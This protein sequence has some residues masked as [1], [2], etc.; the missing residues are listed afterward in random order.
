MLN[1]CS[2][3]TDSPSTSPSFR[4]RLRASLLM[5]IDRLAVD[6]ETPYIGR[7]ECIRA[8]IVDGL[9]YREGEASR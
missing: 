5:K 4:V 3:E 2:E 1:F 6:P 7:R 9:R 8:L